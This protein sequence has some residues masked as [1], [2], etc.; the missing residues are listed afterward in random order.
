[1]T[2]LIFVSRAKNHHVQVQTE[3][4]SCGLSLVY[5]KFALWGMQVQ[6]RPR[7]ASNFTVAHQRTGSVPLPFS[8]CFLLISTQNSEF[9]SLGMFEDV[10]LNKY[11]DGK[12]FVVIG[13]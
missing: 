8:V 12:N 7:T 4:S 2:L 13:F 9:I 10:A 11:T 1:M 6:Q 5:S 3:V